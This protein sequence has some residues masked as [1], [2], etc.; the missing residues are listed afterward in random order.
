MSDDVVIRKFVTGMFQQNTWLVSSAST[1]L[2]IDCGD[3]ITEILKQEGIT[4][5]ALLLTHTHLDH[6][7]DLPVFQREFYDVPSYMHK[8]DLELLTSL[9]QQARMFG[10]P[11]D[12]G[13]P[14]PPTHFVTDGQELSFGDLDVKVVHVDGHTEGGVCYIVKDSHCFSGDMLFA[15][16]VGRTDLPGGNPQKMRESLKRMMHLDGEMKVYSGHGPVTSIGQEV[17]TNPYL[18]DLN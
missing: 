8:G 15:G 2:L 16:S 10:V 4:P 13:I 5:T 9:P 18:Q 12:L 17:A 11:V 7:W 1:H 3:G 14:E 6:A